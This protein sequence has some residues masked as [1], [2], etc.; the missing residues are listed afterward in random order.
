MTTEPG[1]PGAADLSAGWQAIIATRR[2]CVN[3]TLHSLFADGAIPRAIE[4]SPF[5]LGGNDYVAHMS[6]ANA[7]EIVHGDTRD[8]RLKVALQENVS[9]AAG[10]KKPLAMKFHGDV[11][12]T[13]NLKNIRVCVEQENADSL[14][15]SFD[16]AP[17]PD[18]LFAAID[19]SDLKSSP[20]LPFKGR[21]EKEL[22][23]G[24]NAAARKTFPLQFHIPKPWPSSLSGLVPRVA[25]TKVPG[26]PRKDF[27]SLLFGSVDGLGSFD[28][29]PATI[30][31]EDDADTAFIFSNRL[32][33]RTIRAGITHEAQK[34]GFEFGFR[35]NDDY[36]ARI[37][38]TKEVR[39]DDVPL[40]RLKI[41]RRSIRIFMRRGKFHVKVSFRYRNMATFGLWHAVHG[42]SAARFSTG[43]NGN[44]RATFVRHLDVPWTVFLN[45]LAPFMFP[46]FVC[47]KA[48]LPN[49]IDGEG[50]SRI[51]VPGFDVS[52]IS[53]PAYVQI[54]GKVNRNKK[55]EEEAQTR[56]P[57]SRDAASCFRRIRRRI[58]RGIS[59]CTAP[60]RRCW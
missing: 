36:P 19:L 60:F 25:Y 47:F 4:S 17:G 34:D 1:P 59:V 52:S 11:Y 44:L 6:I 56:D 13:V 58:P 9:P 21:V 22:L 18:D 51:F 33:M 28:L 39:L 26:D 7:P 2:R 20:P 35:L 29:S 40:V 32:V 27:L 30:S 57:L 23:G 54:S 55:R 14:L 5:T 49:L 10:T 46:L 8:V 45:V 16:L 31:D 43:E 38:N 24:M 3:E 50:E 48:L 12:V 15:L 41:N 42:S 37:S 53:T